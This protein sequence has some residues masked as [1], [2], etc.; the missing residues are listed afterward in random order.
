MF[1][2]LLL[3]SFIYIYNIYTFIYIY[4]NIF[5]YIYIYIYKYMLLA[6]LY[7]SSRKLTCQKKGVGGVEVADQELMNQETE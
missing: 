5:I 3:F 7:L 4:I 1:E 2:S 6:G